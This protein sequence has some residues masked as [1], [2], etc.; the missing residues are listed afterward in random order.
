MTI[1]YLFVYFLPYAPV[2]YRLG[3]FGFFENPPLIPRSKATGNLAIRDQM[4]ALQWVQ[5]NIV[6]FGGDPDQVTI[7][8][9]SAGGYSMRALLSIPAAFGLYRNAISQSD[10]LGM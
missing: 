8:G 10:L 1:T 3:I 4:M 7:F 9:E 2:D 5:D 6:A